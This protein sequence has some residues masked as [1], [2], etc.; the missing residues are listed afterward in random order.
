MHPSHLHQCCVG[1]Q[2]A[3]VN[4]QAPQLPEGCQQR[5]R[6]SFAKAMS[7]ELAEW[8]LQGIWSVAEERHP[9]ALPTVH[10]QGGSQ[11]GGV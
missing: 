9:D 3:A 11:Q 4:L 7:S 6:I 2:G 5:E 1:Q 10:Y 8:Q